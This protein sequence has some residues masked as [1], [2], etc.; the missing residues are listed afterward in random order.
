M[1]TGTALEKCG[2][3][4]ELGHRSTLLKFDYMGPLPHYAIAPGNNKKCRLYYLRQTIPKNT[5]VGNSDS[6]GGSVQPQD[7]QTF[8]LT[9]ASGGPGASFDADVPPS[10]A[11]EEQPN[12]IPWQAYYDDDEQEWEESTQEESFNDEWS[13]DVTCLPVASEKGP[14]GEGSEILPF[15]KTMAMIAGVIF[16]ATGPL[17]YSKKSQGR[18]VVIYVDLVLPLIYGVIAISLVWATFKAL[19]V[20]IRS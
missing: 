10:N 17:M 12:N 6:T 5:D 1:Q 9:P 11:T 2:A 7:H 14:V 8:P 19:Y 15:L 13:P 20:R 4:G 3:C 18:M 16:L